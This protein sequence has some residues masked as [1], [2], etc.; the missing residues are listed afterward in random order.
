MH[1]WTALL[2]KIWLLKEPLYQVGAIT[3]I[4]SLKI[5]Y[6]VTNNKVIKVNASIKPEN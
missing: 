1:N 3:A 2:F 6:K 5:E 4:V